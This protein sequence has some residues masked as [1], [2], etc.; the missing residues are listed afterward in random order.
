V[1]VGKIKVWR[2][3]TVTVTGEGKSICQLMGGL[4]VNR[5]PVSLAVWTT[6]IYSINNNKL[7]ALDFP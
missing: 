1:K 6:F 5:S 2:G 3:Y 4:V 7:F